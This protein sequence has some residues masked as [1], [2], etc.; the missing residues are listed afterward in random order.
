MRDDSPVNDRN[1][2]RPSASRSLRGTYR[3][4]AAA[5]MVVLAGAGCLLLT[6]PGK[7]VGHSPAESVPPTAEPLPV[8]T[9]PLPPDALP[10][11][12]MEEVLRDLAA[13]DPLPRDRYDL[14]SRFLGVEPDLVATP[15]PEDYSIGDV[16]TFWVENSDTE[17]VSRVSAELVYITPHLYMWVEKG[18]SYD[19]EALAS[20]ARIFEE[21][22]YP[23]N[24]LYFGSEP[25]PGIDGDPRL[26]ILHVRTLGSSVAGYFFSPSEYPASIVPYSN[27]KEMFF[28]SLGATRPGDMFYESVLAHEFQHMI[29]WNVDR[30]EASW[31]NEGLSELAAFLNGYG[32]SNFILYFLQEPDLQLTGWPEGPGAGGPNYGAGFLFTAYF[33]DRLGADALR[34]LVNNPQDGM[35]GVDDTLA[36]LGTGLTADELFTDWVL[37]NL[38]NDPSVEPGY[39]VYPSIPD[40]PPPRFAEEVYSYPAG[41]E[42]ALV[43]QYGTDYIRL[44]GP[45]QVRIRFEGA[46]FVR[47][48]PTS[49]YNTDRDPSTGDSFVWWSNRGD[50]SSMTLTRRFDLSGVEQATLEFDTWYWLESFWDYGYI[51]VSTDGG[52]TWTILSTPHTTTENPHGNAY[53]PGYTGRSADRSGADAEGW[54]HEVVDLSD[55]AGQEIL[56]RFETITDDAVNQPGLLVDNIC[57]PEIGFCDTVE[58]GGDGWE[59]RGF[60]RH[61]NVLPQRF[62]VRVVLPDPDGT[63]QIVPLPLDEDNRGEITVTISERYPATLVVSGLTRYTTE[64]ALYSYSVIPV[65]D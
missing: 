51:E 63:I 1:M 62:A 2:R 52:Q 54:L 4:L 41:E 7:G 24:H 64:P 50:E 25:Q 31:M 33:L 5:L 27:E 17:E 32:P 12:V 14:A 38:L 6:K 21:R 43:H 56:L 53:G 15:E 29:H 59:A 36:Q 34:A 9:P 55:Y 49:T 44:H 35:A 18:V 48:T 58:E 30:N 47:I 22:I 65:G 57:L 11:D 61:N 20:A 3:A 26:H 16:A 8:P 10:Q 19:A 60:V 45:A 39:Y 23:T 37:A 46:Q 28:I 40:L 13:A 42:G